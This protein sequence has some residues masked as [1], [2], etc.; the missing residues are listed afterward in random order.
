[1]FLTRR[2]GNFVVCCT[3]GSVLVKSTHITESFNRLQE[4]L[5]LV[6]RRTEVGMRGSP[7][8][9]LSSGV[10]LEL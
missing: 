5:D 9:S 4:I 2:N 1:M 3:P 7:G 8:S 6:K 10:N